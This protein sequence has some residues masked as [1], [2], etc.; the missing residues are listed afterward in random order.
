[1]SLRGYQSVPYPL[2]TEEWN[3]FKNYVVA[4]YKEA[5]SIAAEVAKGYEPVYKAV[6]NVTLSPLVFLWEKWQIM[7]LDMKMKY[8][9]PEYKA[10]LERIK[11]ESQKIK[12]KAGT[13]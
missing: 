7:S 8:A 5:V 10:E 3:S 12:E 2:G 13:A 1:M 4:Y 9:T 6:L 11:T